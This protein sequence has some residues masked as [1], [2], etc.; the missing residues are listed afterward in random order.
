MD[1]AL[2]GVDWDLISSYTGL[3]S[4]ATF[5][6]YA[7]SYGSLP[8]PKPEEGREGSDPDD[9]A[10]DDGERMTMEDAWL[11]PVMGSV[12]LFGLYLVVKFLGATWLNTI[13]GWYFSIAGVGSV[14]S[15]STSLL[16]YACGPRWKSFRRWTFDFSVQPGSGRETK[17]FFTASARTPAVVLL[18]LALVPSAAYHFWSA[19]KRSILITDILGLSFAHNALSLLK[20]DSFK[21]GSILLSGLFVYDVWWVFGTEVMVKVATTLDLPIK[22]LWPK[23]LLFSGARGYTMLGLGDIVI[24]GTFAALALRYDYHRFSTAPEAPSPAPVAPSG[25]DADSSPAPAK[26][27]ATFDSAPKPYFMAAMAAYVLGLVTTMVVMHTFKAAQPALLYLSPACILSFLGTAAV[28]GEFADAWAWSD[29]PAAEEEQDGQAT[30]ETEKA[31]VVADEKANGAVVPGE[32]ES[33]SVFD[34]KVLG[35]TTANA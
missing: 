34:S 29:V 13:L 5:A 8:S 12:T 4:L 32:K 10:A 1:I 33:S 17:T 14:W 9:N 18:P 2:S 24:P 27:T 16:R 23:S 15:S 21:T 19:G 35:T 7:G 28:R 26:R 11:F 25:G 20:L 6:V 30:S 3:L 31:A 22:I